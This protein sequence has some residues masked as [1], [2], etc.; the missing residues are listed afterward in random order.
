MDDLCFDRYVHGTY[1]LSAGRWGTWGLYN[2]FQIT[3][4]TPFWLD[5]VVAIFV[6]FISIVLCAFLRKQYGEK[7]KIK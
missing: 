5:F 6:I 2:L 3:D 4:F 7:I 1:I